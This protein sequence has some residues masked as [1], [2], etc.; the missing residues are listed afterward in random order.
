MNIGK[1]YAIYFSPTGGTE[2]VVLAAA[3]G[4]GLPGSRLDLTTRQSRASLNLT[5]NSD[6]LAIVGL[7]VYGGR[8]PGRIDNFFTGLK[9]NNTPAVAM[10]VYGNREYEDALIE[11]KVR[12]EERG[13]KVI[14]GAA[15]LGQHTFSENLAQGR[16]D[17][18]DQ[19]L[20]AIFGRKA[21]EN[22]AKAMASTLQVKGNYP[23]VKDVF[24]PTRRAD[25]YSGWAQIGSAQ[26]CDL[27]GICEDNCPWGAISIDENVLTNFS[28]CMRCFRCIRV[29]PGK[30]RKVIDPNWTQFVERFE[31][32]V[33]TAP[34]NPEMFFGD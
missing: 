14:A 25:L 12:L 19:A 30:A 22:I 6:D 32:L 10:V 13:F 17:A 26:D 29:C 31:K 7:P 16:P 34:K 33:G 15:F 18:G 9:G 24:E 21:L 23:Y 3:R 4:T 11:L 27:C 2:K 8:L 28:L 1:V 20:A 5:L